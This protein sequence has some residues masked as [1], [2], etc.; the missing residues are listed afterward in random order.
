MRR[1]SLMIALFLAMLGTLAVVGAAVQT[2]PK[3]AA[4]ADLAT[5]AKQFD[6]DKAKPLDVE[7]K[8]I[9]Q[10]Q[11]YSIHEI[12]YASP[13][14]GRV[15]A[16]LL[17][18]ASAGP[19]PAVLFGH[20]G[21]GDMTEFLAEAEIYA[22]AG[23][24]CLLPDYPWVRPRKWRRTVQNY[25]KPELDKE[26]YRQAVVDLRSGIDLLFGRSDVDRARLGY[27]GHSYGAQWGAILTAVDRRIQ[28]VALVAG[29]PNLDCIFMREGDPDLKEFLKQFPPGQLEKYLEVQSSL[30]A[31]NYVGHS[32]PTPLLFQFAAFDPN[33]N[34]DAMES[35]FAAA[36]EPK[37]ILWYDTGHEL[38]DPQAVLDRY[39]FLSGPLRLAA[40]PTLTER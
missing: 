30:S 22:R 10:R 6:Y 11:G 26:I 29:V 1:T 32:A 34:R 3:P 38:A 16:Y 40:K 4:P 15:P 37:K 25:D 5:L 9:A 12:T 31:V 13:V 8:V 20:W 39:T 18:P 36:S 24:V 33:F 21:G 28:A 19:H 14:S 7:D 23:A 35:Y 2:K 27:I 17:I